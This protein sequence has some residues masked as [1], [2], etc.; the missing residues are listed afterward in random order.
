MT[1]R[2]KLETNRRLYVVCAMLGKVGSGAVPAES[3]TKQDRGDRRKV[4]H[5]RSTHSRIQEPEQVLPSPLFSSH[6]DLRTNF[7][8]S[9]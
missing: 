5:I 1:P 3:C 7:L 6:V 9:I 4:P 2:Y 8:G